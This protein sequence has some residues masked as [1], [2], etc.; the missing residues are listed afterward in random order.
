MPDDQFGKDAMSEKISTRRA[1]RITRV[2]MVAVP[3]GDQDRALEFYVGTLGFEK[4]LDIAHDGGRWIEVAPSGGTTTLALVPAKDGTP[5][6]VD[7]GIRLV[8]DAVHD[9]AIEDMA[10]IHSDLVARGV[11]ADPEVRHVPGIPPMFAFRDP[12][13][14]VLRVVARH[15]PD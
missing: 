4:R 14:N 2:G 6:G 7:T 5:A 15:Q 13:G 1:A 9:D 12:D 10:A 8:L 3:V 11:D